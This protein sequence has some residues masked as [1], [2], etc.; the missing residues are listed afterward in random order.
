MDVNEQNTI[1]DQDFKESN[2]PIGY[3]IQQIWG[4]WKSIILWAICFKLNRF[5]LLIKELHISRKM[6][7]KE[8]K[9]LESNGIIE[10]KSY[11]EVLPRVEYTLTEKGRSVIPLLNFMRV[12]GEDNLSKE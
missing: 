5:S 12:W 9:D 8:L 6:L 2:S 7:S 4:N 10:R 1:K 3:T 11:P